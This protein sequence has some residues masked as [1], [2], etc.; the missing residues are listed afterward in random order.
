MLLGSV[1]LLIVGAGSWSLDATLGRT[2][3]SLDK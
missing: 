3:R 1:F 2:S